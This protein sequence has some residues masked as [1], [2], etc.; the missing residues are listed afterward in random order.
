M[1]WHGGKVA[2]RGWSGIPWSGNL[3]GFY[4]VAMCVTPITLG[5]MSPSVRFRPHAIGTKTPRMLEVEARLGRTL[6]ED[7]LEYYVE[8]GWGQKKLTKRWGV[9]RNAIFGRGGKDDRKY[10]VQ[11]L[12]LPIRKDDDLDRDSEI[13]PDAKQ[14]PSCEICGISGVPLEGAHWI[15]ASKGGNTSSANIIRLCP[16]CHTQLDLSEDAKITTHAQAVLLTRVARQFVES[17]ENFNRGQQLQ[18]VQLCKSI[19]ERQLQNGL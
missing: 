8:K 11:V 10:W 16:N 14:Q 13:E 3:H 18:F 5:G 17:N 4:I 7:F 9:T 19:I 2:G 15:A 12:Q 6:E 1:G